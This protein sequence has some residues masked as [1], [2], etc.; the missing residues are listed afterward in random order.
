MAGPRPADVVR[1]LSIAMLLPPAPGQAG[2]SVLP[3]TTFPDLPS[4]RRY[5]TMTSRRSRL[6]VALSPWYPRRRRRRHAPPGWWEERATGSP[7]RHV[8]CSADYSGK[9]LQR[10]WRPTPPCHNEGG[11]GPPMDPLGASLHHRCRARL[12]CRGLDSRP[13]APRPPIFHPRRDGRAG[14]RR[15]C[16][17]PV[18]GLAR[19]TH[20]KEPTPGGFGSR[21]SC[22]V[23]G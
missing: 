6:P 5:R 11:D 7:A 3:E 19:C 21:A 12:L 10:H 4:L 20:E 13:S 17:N 2:R 16:G 14:G 15:C 8:A 22:P 18:M 9:R 23:R 1:R